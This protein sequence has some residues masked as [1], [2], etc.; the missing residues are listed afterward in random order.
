MILADSGSCLLAIKGDC[1]N[2]PSLIEEEFTPKVLPAV[3]AFIFDFVLRS[4][5]MYS[6]H[7]RSFADLNKSA[8]SLSFSPRQKAS[9]FILAVGKSSP[10]FKPA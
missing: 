5:L 7:K 8:L 3:R 6:I 2:K 10:L 9:A 1:E 4:F